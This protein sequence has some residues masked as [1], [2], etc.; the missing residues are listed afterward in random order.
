MGRVISIVNEK[1]GVGKSTTAWYLAKAFAEKGK[2]TLLIDA[3]PLSGLSLR[4]PDA[5]CNGGLMKYLTDI[6]EPHDCLTGLSPTL[7]IL[8]GSSDMIG[9]ELGPAD[10]CNNRCLNQI[11]RILKKDYE[12][13]VIDTPS[14]LGLITEHALMESDR[15][16]V[17]VCCDYFAMDEIS[18]VM[19]LIHSISMRGNE[20]L[21]LDHFLITRFGLSLRSSSR[22]LDEIQIRYQDLLFKAV[23]P[24]CS[25][26]N[27]GCW[28][29]G[30]LE[31]A[32]M[33][34]ADEL[35]Y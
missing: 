11:I 29:D 9:Y 22:V 12:F 30:D 28:K 23:I 19:K 33:K 16:I 18:Q 21:R 20:N 31:S 25:K 6:V 32:Y 2:N 1:G 5:E 13:V 26:L 27:A 8:L 3:D 15:V 7:D 10:Y 17:P 14:S 24:E 4:N 34:V 35:I